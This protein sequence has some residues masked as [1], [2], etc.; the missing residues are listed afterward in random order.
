MA[1]I[2]DCSLMA[3][4]WTLRLLLD[5]GTVLQPTSSSAVSATA[6]AAHYD[7]QLT[8]GTQ[9]TLS[10]SDG[11]PQAVPSVGTCWMQ[12]GG[13]QPVPLASTTLMSQKETSVNGRVGTGALPLKIVLAIHHPETPDSHPA[14][15]VVTFVLICGRNEHLGS[16]VGRARTVQPLLP[17]V[18][19]APGRTVSGA[20]YSPQ[21]EQRA[22]RDLQISYY[23]V[24]RR[25]EY[26]EKT[27]ATLYHHLTPAAHL[28]Y[29][30]SRLTEDALTP[31]LRASVAETRWRVAEQLRRE[32]AAAVQAEFSGLMG[33]LEEANVVPD[34][35]AS[36]DS[37]R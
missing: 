32:S 28:R 37:S 4:G 35:N 7:V 36:F 23:E 25:A 18:A 20:L 10:W 2:L 19:T 27:V 33:A 8:P 5:D 1:Q 22:Y 9:F 12:E 6:H 13:E 14:E 21:T 11:R 16:D 17:P 29:L 26:F 24:H 34:A 30:D 3:A 31:A 15:P